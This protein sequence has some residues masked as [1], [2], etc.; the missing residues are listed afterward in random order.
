MDK[1]P[2]KIK[3]LCSN[4]VAYKFCQFNKKCN[5]IFSV[6]SENRYVFDYLNTR[7]ANSEHINHIK[8]KNKCYE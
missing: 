4:P 8:H 5:S 2:G 1:L 3:G 7:A 6:D